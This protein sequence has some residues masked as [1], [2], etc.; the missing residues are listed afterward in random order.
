MVLP[1]LYFIINLLTN[2]NYDKKLKNKKIKIIKNNM[3][4]NNNNKYILKNI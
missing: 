3:D 1:L 4:N 2:K